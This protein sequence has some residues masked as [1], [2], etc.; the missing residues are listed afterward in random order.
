MQQNSKKKKQG[1]KFFP[2]QGWKVGIDGGGE[3]GAGIG[4]GTGKR[5]KLT[6]TPIFVGGENFSQC[7]ARLPN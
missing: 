1:W 5:R 7:G 2:N 6:P 3:A 4:T